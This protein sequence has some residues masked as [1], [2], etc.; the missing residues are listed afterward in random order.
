MKKIYHYLVAI[1]FAVMCSPVFAYDFESAGIYYRITSVPNRTVE[2][3]YQQTE[4]D[5]NF[6]SR[7]YAGVVNVPATVDFQGV[8]FHVV[9]IGDNAFYHCDGLSKII[10]PAGLQYIGIEAFIECTGLTDVEIPNTVTNISDRAFA[11]CHSFKNL[12]IPPSV[13]TI[14]DMAFTSDGV[15]SITIQDAPDGINAGGYWGRSFAFPNVVQAYIGRNC[16]GWQA[17]SSLIDGWYGNAKLQRVEFGPNVTEIPY[18][19]LYGD[20]WNL[21]ELILSPNTKRI[22]W[23][24]LAGCYA[25]KRLELPDS[26]EEIEDDALDGGWGDKEMALTDLVI[27]SKIKSIGNHAF[28]GCRNLQTVTVRR[29]DPIAIPEET[30]HAQTYMN[31]TL[32][33]PEGSTESVEVKELKEIWIRTDEEWR[34]ADSA[35]WKSLF[36]EIWTMQGYPEGYYSDTVYMY[37]TYTKEG[38]AHTNYWT[39]FLHRQ[40]G[41]P[42]A[43]TRWPV[44]VIADGSGT[45]KAFGKDLRNTQCSEN[46]EEGI[47]VS[48]LVEPDY[49]YYVSAMTLNNVDVLADLSGASYTLQNIQSRDTLRVTFQAIEASIVI[50]TSEMGELEQTVQYGSTFQFKVVPQEGYVVHSVVFNDVDMTADALAN[51]SIVT[52]A[53][54]GKAVLSVTFETDPSGIEDMHAPQLRVLPTGQGVKVLGLTR[55]GTIAVHGADGSLVTQVQVK[56]ET[57]QIALPAGQVYVVSAEGRSVKVRL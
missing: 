27:G 40:E 12:V 20:A 49:G 45:V 5:P 29:P 57:E 7:S 30:F 25:L 48:V 1:L 23:G 37:N 21:T 10:L 38:Y 13:N 54:T 26:V 50:R 6:P 35:A 32:Y 56:S 11:S 42:A 28:W 53:I 55:G 19:I 47:N 2:V 51:G 24:A 22:C 4:F 3:T 18:C 44:T 9:G 14:G 43:V 17:P 15:E 39:S 41:E 52:P 36:G 8:T 16:G 46:V 33:V 34:D 31:A